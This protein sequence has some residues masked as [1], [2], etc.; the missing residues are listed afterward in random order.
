MDQQQ[1]VVVGYTPTKYGQAAANAAIEE[2]RRRDALLHVLNVSR[3]DAHVDRNL[4]QSDDIATLAQSLNE[5][6]VRH[7]L[8]QQVGRGEPAE[9]ILRAVEETDAA[10]VVIGIRKRSAV[11]K[12]LLGSTAQQVL[13]QV[14]CPVLAVKA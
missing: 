9:E 11:G 1:T 4:A 7:R 14:Q 5:S 2:A 8:V 3:G 10:L 13:L 12:L 6:G